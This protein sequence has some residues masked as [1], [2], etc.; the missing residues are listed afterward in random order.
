MDASICINLKRLLLRSVSGV[1]GDEDG[2]RG[3]HLHGSCTVP[4]TRKDGRVCSRRL[5]AW[6]VTVCGA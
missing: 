2:R 6:E 4:G 5:V 1:S 3:A